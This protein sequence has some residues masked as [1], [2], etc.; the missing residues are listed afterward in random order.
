MKN[1]TK[2]MRRQAS[3]REKIFAKDTSDKG[4]SFKMYKELLKLNNKKIDYL[5]NGPSS[6]N[7]LKNEKRSSHHGAME[8]N[9]SSN[10]E[11]VGSIPGLTQLVKD[12]VLP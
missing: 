3:D 11:V 8:T 1:T 4:L 2:R 10:N 6:E 7:H 12:P 5:I 9:P